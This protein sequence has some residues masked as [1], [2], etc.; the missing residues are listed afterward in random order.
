MMV[1]WRLQIGADK[2]GELSPL[3]TGDKVHLVRVRGEARTASCTASV[4]ALRE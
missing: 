1:A 3:A 4:A 2:F